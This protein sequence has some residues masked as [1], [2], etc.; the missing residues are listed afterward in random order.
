[1]RRL[2]LGQML[3]SLSFRERKTGTLRE[4]LFIGRVRW[5]KQVARPRN[6][7]LRNWLQTKSPIHVPPPRLQ[8]VFQNPFFF[9]HG[10]SE[11][12]IPEIH[13][14]LDCYLMC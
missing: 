2:S 14:C 4:T 9:E 13:I 3:L 6:V 10:L 1:M 12:I 8:P 7:T 11:L 5:A